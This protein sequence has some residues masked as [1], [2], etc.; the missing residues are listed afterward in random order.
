VDEIFELRPLLSRESLLLLQQRRDA[1]SI[2]RLAL[3]FLAFLICGLLLV[4][5]SGSPMVA[6]PLAIALAAMWATFFAVMHECC[7]RNAFQS[8]ALNELGAWIGGILSGFAPSVYRALHVVHH[9]YTNI[10]GKDPELYDAGDDGRMPATALQWVIMTMGVWHFRFKTLLMLK[11]SLFPSRYW[12]EY[13]NWMP[14]GAATSRLVW[15]TRLVAGIWL[16]LFA[17]ALMDIAGAR[18]VLLSLLLAHIVLAVIQ[19]AE[20]R[21][22]ANEGNIFQR[23]RT[24][25]TSGFVRWWMWN[26]NYHAEHH[27][28][29]AIPWHALPGVHERVAQEMDHQ[30]GGFLHTYL[31]QLRSAMCKP[32]RQAF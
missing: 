32:A 14:T 3:H 7:H 22:M 26:A 8:R 18:W 28:W 19:T 21:G 31:R 29:P 10:P 27:A 17:A 20:H 23:T 4:R 2:P 1:P 13:S 24:T 5:F 11:L 16:G 12:K 6:V 9:R 15:E 25:P 30:A